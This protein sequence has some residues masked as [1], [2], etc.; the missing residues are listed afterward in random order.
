MLGLV[1]DIL[2]RIQKSIF[3]LFSFF[4]LVGGDALQCQCSNFNVLWEFVTLCRNTVISAHLIIT[5][6]C[7]FPGFCV[8][9]I[10]HLIGGCALFHWCYRHRRF[11]LFSFTCHF[12]SL[13]CCEFWNLLNVSFFSLSIHI[14]L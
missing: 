10:A 8:I 6:T 7:F 12:N 4:F 1:Y 9:I 13:F 3:F 2:S 11:F 5:S 14:K